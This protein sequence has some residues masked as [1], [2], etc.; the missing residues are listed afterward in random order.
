[1]PVPEGH[2][3]NLQTIKRAANDGRLMLIE[4]T[5]VKTGQPVVVL[6]A[7]SDADDGGYAYV[8]LAKMFDGN[9]YEEL[10]PPS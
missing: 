7:L 10:M 5:D 4:C 3:K 2:K 9:P 1:M 6:G 8:P